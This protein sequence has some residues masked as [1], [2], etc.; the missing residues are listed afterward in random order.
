MSSSVEICNMALTRLGQA[1]IASLTQTGLEA[2]MCNL[3]YDATKKELISSHDWSFAIKRAVLAA[4][5]GDNFTEYSYKYALPTDFLKMINLISSEDY[6]DLTDDYRI[7][8]TSL[9]SNL[10]PCYIKY[11]RSGV[12]DTQFPSQFVQ[13]LYLRLASKMC[14]KL[15]QDQSL[16]GAIYQEFTG[17]IVSAM[18][19]ITA[20]SKEQYHGDELW[21]D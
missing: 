2:E 3:Y 18:A 12:N 13:A 5:S 9:L 8:G 4:E 19:I 10:S 6:S 21:S 17:A 1:R 7:E 14:I 16:L 20:G 11:I 15:T